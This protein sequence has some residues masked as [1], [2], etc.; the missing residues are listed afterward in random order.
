MIISI[1]LFSMN[2]LVSMVKARLPV[3]HIRL[4]L[5]LKIHSPQHGHENLE[6]FTKNNPNL[7]RFPSDRCKSLTMVFLYHPINIIVLAQV[8]PRS[9]CLFHELILGGY[10]PGYRRPNSINRDYPCPARRIGDPCLPRPSCKNLSNS[11]KANA[12]V[13][14][15]RSTPILSGVPP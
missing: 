14:E 8:S 9:F 10:C 7:S 13:I 15:E 11:I 5:N 6:K 2:R 3:K 12:Q 4:L 1:N